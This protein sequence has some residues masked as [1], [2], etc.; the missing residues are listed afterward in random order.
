[1]SWYRRE[2]LLNPLHIFGFAPSDHYLS[3]PLK[4]H[5]TGKQIHTDS[6]IVAEE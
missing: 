5:L 6:T 3:E 4:R 2:T 1:M